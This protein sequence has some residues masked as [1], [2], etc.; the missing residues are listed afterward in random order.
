MDQMDRNSAFA[1]RLPKRKDM[2]KELTGKEQARLDSLLAFDRIW[3]CTTTVCG[4]LAGNT[5]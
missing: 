5:S 4:L 1:G 2:K 3:L